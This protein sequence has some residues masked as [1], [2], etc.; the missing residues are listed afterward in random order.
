MPYVREQPHVIRM[1]WWEWS[2]HSSLCCIIDIRSNNGSPCGYGKARSYPFSLFLFDCCVG[3]KS[4][5]LFV[6]M[7][8][9]SA[10]NAYDRLVPRPEPYVDKPQFTRPRLTAESIWPPAMGAKRLAWTATQLCR[11]GRFMGLY[12]LTR[13]ARDNKSQAIFF[14]GLGISLWLIPLAS[15]APADACDTTISNAKISYAKRW[16]RGLV[17][18]KFPRRGHAIR[19][20][21]LAVFD[22][23]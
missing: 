4:P 20:H 21:G 12:K 9:P 7:L 1:R 5:Q 11:I 2:H 16:P 23:L 17:G 6:G 13:S 8:V 14:V 18:R 3:T 15:M 22:N 19:W 10:F